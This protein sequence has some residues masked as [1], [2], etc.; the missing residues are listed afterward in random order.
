MEII[1][2]GKIASREDA[3]EIINQAIKNAPNGST[4]VLETG[5]YLI[6]SPIRIE[7]KKDF[8]FDGNSST[9]MPFFD[10][11]K[12]E[13]PGSD[14][15]NC[16]NNQNLTLKNFKLHASQHTNSAGK[17]IDVNTEYA[18]V[19]ICA[20][21][22][23][24]GN[25]MFFS[26]MAFSPDGRPLRSYWMH[27]Q[28]SESRR[29][30]IAGEIPTTRSISENVHHE[31]IGEQTYR[32]FSPER[33]AEFGR[34]ESDLVP[35]DATPKESLLKVGTTVAIIHSIYRVCGFAF[36]N[37]HDVL[38]ENVHISNCGGFVFV[39]LPRCSNFTFRKI[40]L[41][42][43]DFV[44]QPYPTNADTI[45]V[46]GLGGKFLLEDCYFERPADDIVNI[47]TQVMV[48]KEITETSMKVIY[49]K[50]LGVVS[51]DWAKP[52]DILK[53]YTSDTFLL[54]GEIEVKTFENGTVTFD[55]PDFEIT[56]SDRITNKA[57][58]SDIVIRNCMARHLRGR[59]CIQAAKS[60]LF[61]NNN[62]DGTSNAV[63][64]TAAFNGYYEAGP[65]EN[66]IIR[67]N[68]F[69]GDNIN[70][71]GNNGVV[72]AWVFASSEEQQKLFHIHKNIT[73]ENNTF[74]NTLVPPVY[75][76]LTDGVT[77]KNNKFI[78]CKTKD[79]ERIIINNC[80][81]ILCENNLEIQGVDYQICQ[82]VINKVSG[83]ETDKFSAKFLKDIMKN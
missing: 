52:K 38:V 67:N 10:R 76:S 27:Q 7:S 21:E 8:V 46:T 29:G 59:F 64:M 30:L 51:P 58:Y 2:I 19:E 53:I 20:K 16:K 43:E 66:I 39:I 3:S 17:V 9:I 83:V 56:E 73:V 1:K 54:K 60:L 78:D 57:Y 45:H 48:P 4:I 77:I 63:Y 25:E 75:I 61:E 34:K 41:K 62:I 18:D 37:C 44:H 69:Y 72:H 14:G 26:G 15:F 82:P 70:V 71:K 49:N 81:E 80:T 22:P 28:G 32:I 6:K 31:M 47:R 35:D 12:D 24:N 42:T 11:T 36:R 50:P 13:N 23:F 79:N 33:L 65:T 5:E 55:K 40:K 68:T 74:M